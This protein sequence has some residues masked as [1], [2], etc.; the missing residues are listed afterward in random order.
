MST[1]SNHNQ[2]VSLLL[3][4]LLVGLILVECGSP[5]REPGKA[6]ATARDS[7][8]ERGDAQMSVD[9]PR[10]RKGRRGTRPRGGHEYV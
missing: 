3:L 8:K 6:V 9:G 10:R 7:V 1:Q 2:R 4:L 5:R